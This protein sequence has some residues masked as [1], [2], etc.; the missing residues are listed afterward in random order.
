ML[1]I[2]ESMGAKVEWLGE[3]TVKI[4]NKNI[5]PDIIDEEKVKKLRSSILLLGSLS[6]RFDKF[7]FYHPGGC[8]I[9]IRPVDTHFLALRKMGVD[10]KQN[11]KYYYANIKERKAGKLVLSEMSVTATE[12]IMMLAAGMPKKTI[13]KL[14]ATEPHVE[15]LGRFLI[16]MGAQIKGLGTHTIEI[17]GRKKLNGVVMTSSPGP[18]FSTISAISS[19]S[20]PDDTPQENAVPQ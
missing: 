11:G 13:I 10:I 4:T 9:G 16:S 7:K 3:R 1:E 8:V 18:M 12:N 19:A 6:A 5:N 2:L 20:D 15:D 14:A 17:I